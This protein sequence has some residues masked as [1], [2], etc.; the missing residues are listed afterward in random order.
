MTNT[1]VPSEGLRLCYCVELP[2]RALTPR[3][4]SFPENLLSLKQIDYPGLALPLTSHT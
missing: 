3:M 1:M 4:S 2:S